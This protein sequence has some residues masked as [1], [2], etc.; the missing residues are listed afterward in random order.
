MSDVKLT[1]FSVRQ[2]ELLLN[3]VVWQQND[4]LTRRV[5][6][7]LKEDNIE[8]LQLLQVQILNA[9]HFV[10]ERNKVNNN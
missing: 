9:L 1:E 3:G 10:K 6:G 7:L 4:N 8:D 2:L 5:N